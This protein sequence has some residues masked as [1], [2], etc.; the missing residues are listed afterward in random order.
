MQHLENRSPMTRSIAELSARREGIPL[1]LL[2][3]LIDLK[4]FETAPAYSD[5]DSQHS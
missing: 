5:F 1:A 2:S 4:C 3:L